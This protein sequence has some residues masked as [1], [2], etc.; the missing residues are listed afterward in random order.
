M[1]DKDMFDDVFP[2]G[3]QVGGSH[4]V[5]FTIQ[6]YEFIAKNDLTFFQGNVIKYVCR[7]R[8]KNGVEDLDKIIHYC[9]L[10]K[11]KLQDEKKKK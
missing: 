11:L 10:E 6:P 9:E 8:F 5:H 7:Y 4:Y 1:T 3:R 2:Q